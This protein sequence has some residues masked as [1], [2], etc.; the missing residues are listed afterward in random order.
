[1]PPMRQVHECPEPG[2][3]QLESKAHHTTTL[4]PKDLSLK[5][6]HRA[7]HQESAGP[8]PHQ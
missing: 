6:R 3:Q 4:L 5:H 7:E 1:M 2:P 8:Q